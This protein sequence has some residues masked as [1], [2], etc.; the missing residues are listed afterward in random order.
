MTIAELFEKYQNDRR[1]ADARAARLHLESKAIL[2]KCEAEGERDLTPQE[3]ERF[4]KLVDDRDAARDASTRAEINMAKAEKAM[5]DEDE[6]QRKSAMR[7][8]TSAPAPDGVTRT[9]DVTPRMTRDSKGN[10]VVHTRDR[11]DNAPVWTR[12][13]GRIA[14]VGRD[15]RMADN[16]IVR[17]QIE[18]DPGRHI[19][20]NYSGIGQLVRN[21]STTGSSALIPSVWGASIIDKARNASQVLNAGAEVVAMDAKVLN[22]GRLITD[23]TAAWLAEGATRTESDPAWDLVSL[24]S[25][26]LS[27]LTVASLEFLQDAPNADSVVE[28]SIGKAMG[29]AIDSAALFGGVTVGADAVAAGSGASPPSP[30]GILGNLLANAST[31]ILGSGANGTAITAETPWN[32]LLDTYFTPMQYNEKP[33]AILM[34]SK[35]QQKYSKTYDTLGQPLRT[36]PVLDNTPILITNQIPSFTQGTMTNIAT[37]IFTGDYRQVLWG[38]RLDITTRVLSERYAEAGS[39]GILSTFRGDIVLARPRA[40]CVYRYIGGA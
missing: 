3:F 24:T 38:T 34:N 15:E 22:L 23:P 27:C 4:T 35:M 25:R 21:L 33:T 37:D 12:E 10:V 29:L 18:R 16:E 40:M 26:T 39:V 32:E 6:V 17:E 7:I 30:L 8:P 19:T 9:L 2:D 31:S 11:A 36:P 5:Q 13:D 20:D 14:T 28:D 1:A